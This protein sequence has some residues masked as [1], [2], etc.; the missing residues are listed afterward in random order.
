MI[1][2]ATLAPTAF[3][4]PRK[5][6]QGGGATPD[7]IVCS[8]TFW[9]GIASYDQGVPVG[10]NTYTVEGERVGL[11]DSTYTNDYCGK[12]YSTATIFTP[13]G[14]VT[15]CVK[16]DLH[17]KDSGGTYHDMTGSTVCASSGLN[18]TSTAPTEAAISGDGIGEYTGSF[19]QDFNTA[20]VTP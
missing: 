16:A 13:I 18:N 20:T 2:T 6:R 8:R 17:Y 7:Y 14:A 3:A 9:K 1:L 10:G 4:S 5:A 15:E 19:T 11:F 12:M